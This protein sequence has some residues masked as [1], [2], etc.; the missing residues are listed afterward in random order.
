MQ[1]GYCLPW[2]FMTV[3]LLVVDD[4][5]AIVFALSEYFTRRGWEVDCARGLDEA[6]AQVDERDYTA[7]I[8]DL[9]L[10]GSD[11]TEGL[12]LIDYLRA[13]QPEVVCILLTAYGSRPVIGQALKRGAARVLHKPVRLSELEDELRRLIGHEA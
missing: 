10:T 8:I 4:E 3:R 6:T 1:T 5:T 11:S 13:K 7:V 9:R 12:T 2:A